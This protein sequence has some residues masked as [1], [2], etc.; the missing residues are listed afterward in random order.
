[1]NLDIVNLVKLQQLDFKIEKTKRAAQEGPRKLA[2]L[3]AQLQAA[4]TRVAESLAKEQ[5]ALKRRRELE[6]EI[7]DAQEKIK[8][9]QARQLQVKTNEEYRAMLK[10]SD[11]LK[12]SNSTREDEILALMESLEALVEENKGLKVWLEEEK[13]SLAKRKKEIEAWIRVSLEESE[14]LEIERNSILKDIPGN[15]T[16]LYKRIY[17]G[18]NGRAVVSIVDGIC[19]ECHL[20]IPPQEYNELQRNEKVQVCPNCQRIIFWKEHRDFEDI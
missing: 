20:Q 9:N 5:D 6:R 15:Y 18:R 1:M 3:D 12:K 4:E 8:N 17:A 10:E 13:E 16:A 14:V 19:Q 7:D 11:F 2:E